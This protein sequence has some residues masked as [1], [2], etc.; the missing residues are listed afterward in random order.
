MELRKMNQTSNAKY[1]TIILFF[2]FLFAGYIAGMDQYLFNDIDSARTVLLIHALIGVLFSLYL[3][4]R[5][6][7]IKVLMYVEAIYLLLN[8]VYS[9]LSIGQV[10]DPG[11]HDPL[12]DIWLTLMQVMF[13]VL[14]LYYSMKVNKENNR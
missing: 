2:R 9:A 10:I 1:L 13:S 7:G 11:L 4:G 3:F 8:L 6:I 14:T 12:A 5:R